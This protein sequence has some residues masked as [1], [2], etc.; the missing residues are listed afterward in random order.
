MLK[1]CQNNT[2]SCQEKVNVKRSFFVYKIWFVYGKVR[3][4]MPCVCVSCCMATK[5]R[6]FPPTDLPNHKVESIEV[7]W[8]NSSPLSGLTTQSLLPCCWSPWPSDSSR[9]W[10][11]ARTRP[12]RRT[13]SPG[14]GACQQYLLAC[15]SVPVLC[16]PS[17]FWVFLLRLLATA[18]NSSTCASD[19]AS[20][21]CWRLF[22][23]CQFSIDW[24]SPAPIRSE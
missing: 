15:R 20:T 17:K 9:P 8:W 19:R 21:P 18:L 12:G 24:A 1:R 3:N 7:K 23:S 22:Y 11:R 13:S 6:A 5:C 10:R 14:V 4:I 16:Q 2:V